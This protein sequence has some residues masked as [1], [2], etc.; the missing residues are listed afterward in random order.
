L[1]GLLAAMRAAHDRINEAI[2]AGGPVPLRPRRIPDPDGIGGSSLTWFAPD[3]EAARRAVAALRAE[4]APAA[5]MYDGRPV[6][7]NP[8]VRNRTAA[9][10]ARDRCPV[11]E[12]LVARS[13]TIG[14]GPAFTESDCEQIATAFHKVTRHLVGAT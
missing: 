2:E 3:P 14:I 7:A 13:I 9:D 5:Q 8:A 4:G 10:P 6:Y 11:T 1:P 12:D